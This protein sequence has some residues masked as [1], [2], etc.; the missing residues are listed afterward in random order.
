MDGFICGLKVEVFQPTSLKMLINSNLMKDQLFA[1]KKKSN[2]N[3]SQY[4]NK[5]TIF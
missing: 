1:E 3:K 5:I 4:L 2:I